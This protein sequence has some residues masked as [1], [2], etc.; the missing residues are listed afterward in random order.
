MRPKSNYATTPTAH[1]RL[2]AFPSGFDH[3]RSVTELPSTAAFVTASTPTELG[4]VT[5]R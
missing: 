2:D 5:P 3:R 4:A 1:E